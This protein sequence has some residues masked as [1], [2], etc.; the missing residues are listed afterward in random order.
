LKVKR[1][2]SKPVEKAPKIDSE[3]LKKLQFDNHVLMNRLGQYK[4]AEKGA[5]DIVN[6]YEQM[7]MK[8]FHA[9]TESQQ[10]KLEIAELI[11]IQVNRDEENQKIHKEKEKNVSEIYQLR[12]ELG[13]RI[14]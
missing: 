13:K 14:S 4:K 6:D 7:K 3:F 9:L 12:M 8:Y 2:E 5:K 1:L 11:K 10:N